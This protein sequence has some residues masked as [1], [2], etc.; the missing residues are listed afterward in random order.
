MKEFVG[1][2]FDAVISSVT[3]F[4]FF[5]ELENGVEGLVRATS[6]HEDFYNYV[7]S[8]FALIGQ[9]TGK[10]FHVGDGVRVRLIEADVKL[11]Q[12]TFK[13]VPGVTAKN[14]IAEI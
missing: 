9:R 8:E 2:N 7:D 14:L 12:L 1:Q 3:N 10:S 4:G 5:V 11:R 6:L 13:L